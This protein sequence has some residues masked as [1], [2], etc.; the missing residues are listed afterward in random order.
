MKQKTAN[1]YLSPLCEETELRC[2]DICA[3][4]DWNTD[5]STGVENLGTATDMGDDW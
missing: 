4:S 5:G 1:K 3:T 2:M